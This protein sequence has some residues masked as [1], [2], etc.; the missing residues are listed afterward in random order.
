MIPIF[1]DLFSCGIRFECQL[2]GLDCDY[3]LF[4][5]YFVL[6]FYI[7]KNNVTVYICFHIFSLILWVSLLVAVGDN[8]VLEFALKKIDGFNLVRY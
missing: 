7:N 3:I 6:L 1:S 8:S 4:L 5:Y 2:F